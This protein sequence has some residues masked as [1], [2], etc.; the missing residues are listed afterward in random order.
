MQILK[1]VKVQKATKSQLRR[2]RFKRNR[3]KPIRQAWRVYLKME[4]RKYATRTV[5]NSCLLRLLRQGDLHPTLYGQARRSLDDSTP[6]LLRAA[7]GWLLSWETSGKRRRDM[8]E[9]DFGAHYE[10]AWCGKI[11]PR[12]NTRFV[13]DRPVCNEGDC[14]DQYYKATRP[15]PLDRRRSATWF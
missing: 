14:R 7:L 8:S 12:N 4:V 15:V 2:R 9:E 1:G 13:D 3:Q 10:C 11:Q 6:I 5:W